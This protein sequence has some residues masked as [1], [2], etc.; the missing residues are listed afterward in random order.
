MALRLHY[1]LQCF[2]EKYIGVAH[3]YCLHVLQVF[4]CQT[5]SGEFV[6]SAV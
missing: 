5:D 2:S 4:S 6:V 3:G 1:N